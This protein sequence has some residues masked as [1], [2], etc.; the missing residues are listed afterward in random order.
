MFHRRAKDLRSTGDHLYKLDTYKPMGLGRMYLR[1]PRGLANVTAK[2]H[3]NTFDR[4][5]SSGEVPA[6]WKRAIITP[7]HRKG[8]KDDLGNYR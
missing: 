7:I 2:P 6:D 8:K 5:W 3:F 1:L 4:S